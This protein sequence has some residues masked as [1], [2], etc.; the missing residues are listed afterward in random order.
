[1]PAHIGTGLRNG[2]VEEQRH[3]RRAT[4]LRRLIQI[5]QCRIQVGIE[6]RQQRP[7]RVPH[8]NTPLLLNRQPGGRERG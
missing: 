4:L 3:T 7:E 5:E 2:R 1:M 8:L 6:H